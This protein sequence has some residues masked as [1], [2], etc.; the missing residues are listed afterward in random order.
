MT[1]RL[2]IVGTD[3]ESVESWMSAI[4]EAAGLENPSSTPSMFFFHF[5]ILC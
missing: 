1:L 5:Y 4:K 2:I 3:D